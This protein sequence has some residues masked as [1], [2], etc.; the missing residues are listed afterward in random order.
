M[1]FRYL[2]TKKETTMNIKD[3]LGKAIDQAN[4]QIDVLNGTDTTDGYL[5]Y[6]HNKER[7]NSYFIRPD[8]TVEFIK[9]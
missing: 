4:E 7:T 2:K 3:N 6:L 8:G 1:H 5:N 9:S